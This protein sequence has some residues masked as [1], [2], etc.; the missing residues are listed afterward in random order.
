[1]PPVRHVVEEDAF[2]AAVD[3]IVRRDFFPDVAISGDKEDERGGIARRSRMGTLEAPLSAAEIT[4][5]AGLDVFS[6]K[7][8]SEDTASFEDVTKRDREELER[9]RIRRMGP[10]A[11][12]ISASGEQ[13]QQQ[14]QIA[15][16]AG[17]SDTLTLALDAARAATSGVPS[18][19]AAARRI[20]SFLDV[21]E[22]HGQ[23]RLLL[24]GGKEPV[25]LLEGVDPSRAG[26]DL[27]SHGSRKRCRTDG[28]ETEPIVVAGVALSE[29]ES[30]AAARAALRGA[31]QDAAER[32]HASEQHARGVATDEMREKGE[33]THWRVSGRWMPAHGTPQEDHTKP[34]QIHLD[35][36]KAQARLAATE[37]FDTVEERLRAHE[38]A[39]HASVLHANTRFAQPHSR[40]TKKAR[41]ARPE[42]AGH[43][44]QRPRSFVAMTPNVRP[45]ASG[46]DVVDGNDAI[47]ATPVMTF[48]D[49]SATPL[50][51]SP[52]RDSTEP[53]F[54]G[55][56]PEMG[57]SRHSLDHLPEREARGHALAQAAAARQHKAK[58]AKAS[59]R[60]AQKRRLFQQLTP[61]STRGRTASTPLFRR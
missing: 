26:G 19:R 10:L 25:L 28:D 5:T 8:V 52:L 11:L 18:Q 53:L 14:A 46:D 41:G 3:H 49:V 30:R 29:G 39:R 35:H 31:Q 13:P 21:E 1:M 57:E 42:P 9:R 20:S 6:R 59:A 15:L 16:G 12:A 51:L 38:A 40:P 27:A 56:A 22:G 4:P 47:G 50:L 32:I 58:R 17:G 33:V 48:G 44:G 61:G 23:P 2:A 45:V 7:Y 36:E 37:E 60:E 54:A 55:A 43:Q 24:A 34:Q